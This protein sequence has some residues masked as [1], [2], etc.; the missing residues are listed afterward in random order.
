MDESTVGTL[1]EGEVHPSAHKAFAWV[2]EK[3]IDVPKY[4]R[5]LEAMSSCAIEG[6]RL[7]EVCGE[8]LRRIMNGQNISDRYLL[9]LAWFLKEM[10]DNES[11]KIKI[12]KCTRKGCDKTHEF[13][14]F[15][16]C[17]EHVKESIEVLEK[18]FLSETLTQSKPNIADSNEL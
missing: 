13:K 17:A 5:L 15:N 3:L 4:F 2:K 18:E 6:N 7:A 8:T 1:K 12:K 10:E 14:I 11:K 9:G 16:E